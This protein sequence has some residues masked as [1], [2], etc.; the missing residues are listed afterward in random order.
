MKNVILQFYEAFRKLDAEAM[1]ECYH[2]DVTFEDPAFG[3]LKGEHASNMW[4][5][6]CKT[7]TGKDFLVVFSGIEEDE[8]KGKA[9]W[10]AHY[11][12]SQ[13]GRRVHNIIEASFLLKDGKII[14]HTDHF[15]L[16]RWAR[17]AMGFSGFL[18][19]WSGFFKKK[20]NAKTAGLL[21]KFEASLD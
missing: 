7:Q 17:Q 9:H 3:V 4:R 13:T 20:L 18:I 5:M 2:P 8:E 14:Q 21:A 11:T 16:Y 12:F 6:L 1:A 10:E 15:P 19:G